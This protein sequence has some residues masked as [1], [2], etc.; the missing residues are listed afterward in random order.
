MSEDDI[1]EVVKRRLFGGGTTLIAS[2]EAQM[3][4]ISELVR[5]LTSLICVCAKDE[6]AAAEVARMCSVSLTSAVAMGAAL[7]RM[8]SIYPGGRMPDA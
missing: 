5:A 8:R 2:P 4:L 7:A 1:G 3:D 6:E